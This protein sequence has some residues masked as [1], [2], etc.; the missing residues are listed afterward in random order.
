MLNDT[1]KT[2]AAELLRMACKRSDMLLFKDYVP[3]GL[4]VE[5]VDAGKT[6]NECEINTISQ[7]GHLLN[8]ITARAV[9]KKNVID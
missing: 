5:I 4:K 3:N 8:W 9:D 7:V 1:Q 6:V 2:M